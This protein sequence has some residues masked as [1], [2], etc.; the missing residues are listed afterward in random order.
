MQERTNLDQELL[1]VNRINDDLKKENENLRNLQSDC[2]MKLLV[3]ADKKR[4]EENSTFD[5]FGSFPQKEVHF[6]NGD[7]VGKYSVF[8]VEDE[9]R[10]EELRRKKKVKEN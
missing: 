8:V 10:E 7:K 3:E 5:L 2:Q 9:K 1:L 6:K 4:K